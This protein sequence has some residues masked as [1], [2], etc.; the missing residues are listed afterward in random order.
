[1]RIRGN[2]GIWAPKY[3]GLP[4]RACWKN[5]LVV[6]ERQRADGI[7]RGDLNQ[8]IAMRVFVNRVWSGHF[9]TG[10]VDTPSNFG[11]AGERPTNPDLLEY[12]ASC[13]VKNGMSVKKLQREILLSS[14]YQLSTED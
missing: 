10:I 5:S 14:V 7:G 6:H 3:R 13:F 2:P 11:M 4:E 1:M 8:P 9:G 12:L